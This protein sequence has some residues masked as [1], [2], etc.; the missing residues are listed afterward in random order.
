MAE[1]QLAA[2]LIRLLFIVFIASASNF[3]LLAVR[4]EILHFSYFIAKI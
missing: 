4:F 1:E 2:W 3:K